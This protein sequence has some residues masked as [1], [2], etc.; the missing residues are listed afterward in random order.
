M[1]KISALD[2]CKSIIHNWLASDSSY[3]EFHLAHC[4]IMGWQPVWSRAGHDVKWLKSLTDE[5]LVEAILELMYMSYD[6]EEDPALMCFWFK[7]VQGLYDFFYRHK[8]KL[9]KESR[10]AM[11]D[12]ERGVC[13]SWGCYHSKSKEDLELLWETALQ[14]SWKAWHHCHRRRK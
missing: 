11:K 13:F 5:E 12:F 3:N 14:P 9:G 4:A 7:I 1:E 10:K 8:I 6:D 2:F